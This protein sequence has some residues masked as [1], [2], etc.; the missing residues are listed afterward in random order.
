M[1]G[2]YPLVNSHSYGKQPLMV[3]LPLENNDFLQQSRPTRWFSALKKYS[4]LLYSAVDCYKWSSDQRILHGRESWSMGRHQRTC[5]STSHGKTSS[6][7]MVEMWSL[8]IWHFWNL[9]GS[10]VELAD[11]WP[12]VGAPFWARCPD[13]LLLVCYHTPPQFDVFHAVYVDLGVPFAV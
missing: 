7:E 1:N 4:M 10:R 3:N 13:W 2:K 8:G 5:R 12:V 6:G 9:S 11:D